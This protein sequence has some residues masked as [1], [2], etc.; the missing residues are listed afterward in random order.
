M[1]SVGAGRGGRAW[2]KA[3][4]LRGAFEG[5]IDKMLKAGLG[6]K[7]GRKANAHHPVEAGG[8]AL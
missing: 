4:G 2:G 8:W 7:G 1:A 6:V 3:A 5:E